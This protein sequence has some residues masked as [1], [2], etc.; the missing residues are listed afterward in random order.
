MQNKPLARQC[1][2]TFEQKCR[3]EDAAIFSDRLRV[4]ANCICS[5]PALVLRRSYGYFV[6]GWQPWRLAEALCSSQLQFTHSDPIV[7]DM[8]VGWHARHSALNLVGSGL[9]PVACLRNT[10][11]KTNG[12]RKGM[13]PAA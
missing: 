9:T 8:V 11:W 4:A 6:P 12:S 13:Y 3:R 1:S 5:P 2:T 10:C 7:D